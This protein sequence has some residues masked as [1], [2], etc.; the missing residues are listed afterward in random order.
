MHKYPLHWLPRFLGCS[1]QNI[2]DI[3]KFST[4]YDRLTILEN[5]LLWGHMAPTAPD[6]LGNDVTGV[7]L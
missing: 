6:T 2:D 4:V 3:F 1:G 5:T 7:N